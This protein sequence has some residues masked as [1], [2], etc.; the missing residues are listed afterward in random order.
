M[1]DHN[2]LLL[3][4]RIRNW[5]VLPMVLLMVMVGVGRSLIQQLIKS[6]P[7]MDE[8]EFDKIRHKQTVMR[9]DRLRMI[10]AQL[11]NKNAFNVRKTYLIEEEKGILNEKVSG[12]NMNPMSNPN[13]MGDMLKGQLTF[14]LPNFALMNFVNSFFSGFVCL[15][16]PFSMPSNHFKTM[17]Q[18]G[19]DLRELDVSYVSSISWYILL[20][21]GLSGVYRLILDE[22]NVDPME[23]QKQQ[24]TMGMGGGQQFDAKAAYKGCRDMLAMSKN[25]FDARTVEAEKLLLGERYPQVHADTVDL[26]K[27]K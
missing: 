25:D 6:D 11:I 12:P 1:V 26:S 15:K 24:M 23:M 9:G 2:L 17:L 19:V 3:D 10:G 14:M 4:P 22:D 8:K 20:T 21:F 13:M 18:R 5:V 16:V 7:V 27:F